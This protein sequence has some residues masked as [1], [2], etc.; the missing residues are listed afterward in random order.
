MQEHPTPAAIMAAA[1]RKL[2]DADMP[3]AVIGVVMDAIA[4]ASADW[5]AERAAHEA[6]AAA[7]VEAFAARLR[8]I[9]AANDEWMRQASHEQ[10]RKMVEAYDAR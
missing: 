6:A 2:A 10:L 8:A 3:P 7:E 1:M 4:E 9:V 5:Q